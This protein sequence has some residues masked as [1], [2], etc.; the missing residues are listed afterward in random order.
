MSWGCSW[1]SQPTRPVGRTCESAVSLASTAPCLQCTFVIIVWN[2]TWFV[3]LSE[4]NIFPFSNA[5]FGT[6]HR[7]EVESQV[8]WFVPRKDNFLSWYLFPLLSEHSHQRQTT[9]RWF[10]VM[11][12]VL[13]SSA[14]TEHMRPTWRHPCSQ[15]YKH[16]GKNERKGEV[17]AEKAVTKEQC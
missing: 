11:D 14:Y 5:S 8:P 16:M 6:F 1:R 13:G 9:L 12:L 4:Q 2:F 7:S 17:I 3:S 10:D 15:L